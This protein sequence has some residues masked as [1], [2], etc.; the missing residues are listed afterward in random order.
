MT[1][2]DT[3]ASRA[4]TPPFDDV[5]RTHA[6]RVYR[7]C[8]S[9]VRSSQDAE[10]LAADVFA[11]ACRAYPGSGVTA[12]TVLPWLLR[13]ARNATIDHRRRLTRRAAVVDRYFGA[14]SETDPTANVVE[15]VVLRDEVRRMLAAMTHLSEKDRAVLGLRVAAGLPHAQ[16]AEVLGIT[17]HAATMAANRAL[18]R[19]RRHLEPR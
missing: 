13:I 9:Q 8:L 1:T 5:Y 10:D 4:P 14:E 11:S 18:H 6:S 3:A 16:V 2:I 19:L 12:G 7:Y 15:Q 17:E